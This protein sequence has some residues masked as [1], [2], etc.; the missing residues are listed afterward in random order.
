M[1]DNDV[2]TLFK[3]IDKFA[4]NQKHCCVKQC[5]FCCYQQ[6]EVMNIER[7]IIR[8]YV[9]NILSDEQKNIIRE[10]ISTWLDYFDK[11]T[12][13]NVPL[14]GNQ[15]FNVFREKSSLAKL[16][17]PFL[18]NNECSIYEA[19]PFTCRIHVVEDKPELC[20]SDRF[21][22]PKAEALYLRKVTVKSLAKMTNLSVEPLPYVVA[23][24]LV[25]DRK[26]KRLEKAV[27]K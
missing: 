3:E 7:N 25:P 8:E 2:K 20:D 11:N 24:L 21:R 19:R 23:D 1:T 12:P 6:I 9:Q 27:L 13:N 16:K 4:Q 14:D 22:E 15:I 10:D 17:C 5:S 18:I 26:L